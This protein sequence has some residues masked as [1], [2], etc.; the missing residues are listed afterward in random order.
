[1]KLIILA[2][3]VA[4]LVLL[5]AVAWHWFNSPLYQPGDVRAAKDLREP[6]APPSQDAAR[7]GYWRVASDIELFHIEEGAGEPILTIHGGPGFVPAGVWPAGAALG[8]DYR[9]VYYHQRGCGL[10]TRPIG[11]LPDQNF[12]QSMQTLNRTL[13]LPAQVADIERIRRILGREKLIL[14]GHSFGAF[15]AVLYAAEFPEHVRAVIAVAPADLAVLPTPDGGLFGQ[16]RQGLPAE[17]LPEYEKFL[18]QYFDFKGAVKKSDDQLAAMYRRFGTFYL[19]ASPAAAQHAIAGTM[20]GNGG[21]MPL[22]IYLSMGR[23]HDY[24]DAFRRITAPVLVIHGR[25]DLQP[26]ASSRHFGEL[27]PNHR[28]VEVA[29]AGHF[30]FADQPAAFAAAVK[31]FLRAL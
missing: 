5:A 10:S 25:D 19:A 21:M 15:L 17:R 3:I 8:A 24:S 31:E 20:E 22:A 12:Y 27:F 6:L 2:G 4:V 30:V 29:G 28:M 18:A 26:V 1:M 11:S 13:G 23:R 9:L 7:P 14:V 16:V